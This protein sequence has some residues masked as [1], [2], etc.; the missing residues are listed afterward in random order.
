[1]HCLKTLIAR[2]FSCP[3]A[4]CAAVPTIADLRGRTYATHTA[5]GTHVD[6]DAY[7]ATAAGKQAW[8]NVVDSSRRPKPVAARWPG[9]RR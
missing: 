4:G 6:L 5:T 7:F 2:L 1:M 3:S 9:Q 8:N